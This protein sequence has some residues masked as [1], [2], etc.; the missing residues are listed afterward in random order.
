MI[1]GFHSKGYIFEHQDY[2]SLIVGS[3]NLTDSALKAN[4]EWNVFLTSLEDG[5]IIHHFKNQ[6]EEAWDEAIPLTEEWINNYNLNYEQQPFVKQ[7]TSNVLQVNDR[8][9]NKSFS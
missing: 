9:F 7:T 8:I 5:E 3:S 4:Y 6:F 1:K 2:Y